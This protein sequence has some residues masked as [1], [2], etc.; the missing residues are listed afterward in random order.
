[1]YLGLTSPEDVF[2]ISTP[3]G[4]GYDIMEWNGMEWNTG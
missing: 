2:F 1:M 4:G 3:E